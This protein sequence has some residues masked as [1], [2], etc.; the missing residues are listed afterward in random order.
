MLEK[1]QMIKK[2]KDKGFR[3]L[4]YLLIPMLFSCNNEKQTIIEKEVNIFKDSDLEYSIDIQNNTSSISFLLDEDKKII[5]VLIF[6]DRKLVQDF[7]LKI[8]KSKMYSFVKI[9]NNQLRLENVFKQN[10]NKRGFEVNFT[11]MRGRDDLSASYPQILNFKEDIS[12]EFS[13]LISFLKKEKLINEFLEK[14][15]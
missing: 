3:F 13:E 10:K 4:V 6:K 7:F 9:I 12:I 11:I 14:N 1:N 2:G 8:D 15:K 5:N